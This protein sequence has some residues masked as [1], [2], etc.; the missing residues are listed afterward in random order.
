MTY[1]HFV[2]LRNTVNFLVKH[3]KL[4]LITTDSAKTKLAWQF[5]L[6]LNVGSVKIYISIKKNLYWVKIFAQF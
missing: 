6:C 2:S 3:D 4:K 1:E 5:I